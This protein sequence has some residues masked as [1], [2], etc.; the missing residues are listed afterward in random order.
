MVT[1]SPSIAVAFYDNRKN[2]SG[3]FTY[4]FVIRSTHD[5]SYTHLF[6]EWTSLGTLR[7]RTVALSKS[8]KHPKGS[9]GENKL[10]VH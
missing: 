2:H 5:L 7:D 3:V 6:Y 4:S 9:G 8:E 10:P 1:P